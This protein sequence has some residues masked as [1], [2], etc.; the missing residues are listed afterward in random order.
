MGTNN[1]VEIFRSIFH[2]CIHREGSDKLWEFIETES[3]FLKDPASSRYHLDVPHG[4]IIHSINV[5]HRLQ[6]LCDIES[7]YNLKFNRPSDESIAIV[8]LF[9]DLCK[10]DTYGTERK[11][12]KNYDE[13]AISKVESWQVKHDSQGDFI[14]D[15]KLAYYKQDNFPYGHGEK[16]VYLL[17]KFIEL[18]DEEALAI[19][20]HMASWNNEEKDQASASFKINE[21][22]FLTHVADEWA[23][24]VDEVQ[25]HF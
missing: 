2:E 5:Y 12:F 13:Y 22:A 8:G 10:A 20:Y 19:R 24:F 6:W 17:S 23:T 1:S 21:F 14:L 16:S 11:N 3:N 25:T 4:L 15:S 18:T 7:E 9:H